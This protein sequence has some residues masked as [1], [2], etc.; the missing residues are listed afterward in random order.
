MYY[1]RV[2]GAW[3]TPTASS[4]YS[5]ATNGGSH[6]STSLVQQQSYSS[7]R[8]LYPAISHSIQQQFEQSGR[9]ATSQAG[10]D[11]LAAPSYAEQST[12]LNPIASGGGANS[13]T[14]QTAGPSSHLSSATLSSHGSS[15]QNTSTNGSS[16]AENNYRQ[17]HAASHTGGYYQSASSTPQQSSFPSFSAGTG[18]PQQ[19]PTAAPATTVS[20]TAPRSSSISAGQPGTL[21]S[22]AA[23]IGYGHPANRHP[24]SSSYPPYAMQGNPVLSNMHHPGAPLAMVGGISAMGMTAAYGPPGAHHLSIYGHGQQP[25]PQDRP[26]KCDQCPQSFNRNHDLKRHKR[27]HLA[28]KPFPC[29]FCEKSFSRKDALKRH[30]LVKGCG[31]KK[32][33]VHTDSTNAGVVAPGSTPPPDRSET[34]S[35]DTEG[36]PTMLKRVIT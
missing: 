11:G 28:V 19:S 7:S 24:P 13:Q 32:S 31:E 16:T 8:S 2:T 35:D 30:R 3:P 23:S 21:A 10:V 17:Q 14:S 36:S 29:K 18:P 25:P 33:P 27:I 22:M 1:T 9:P 26:F 6:S 15:A 12:A 20:S 34:T 4:N 5:F